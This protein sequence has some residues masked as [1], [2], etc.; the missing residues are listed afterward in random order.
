M[1]GGCGGKTNHDRGE[2]HNVLSV[3]II[4][5]VPTHGC[6]FPCLNCFTADQR[7]FVNHPLPFH[8]PNTIFI[9]FYTH[10]FKVNPHESRN[11]LDTY[12]NNAKLISRVWRQLPLSALQIIY[13][14]PWLYRRVQKLSNRA[15]SNFKDLLP[16][17]RKAPL[18]LGTNLEYWLPHHASFRFNQSCR[19]V[20]HPAAACRRRSGML[21]RAG[22][23]SPRFG[24]SYEIVGAIRKGSQPLG[25][26]WGWANSERGGWSVPVGGGE[27]F[28]SGGKIYSGL[29]GRWGGWF[30]QGCGRVC[31][32]NFAVDTPDWVLAY[33]SESLVVSTCGKTWWDSIIFVKQGTRCYLISIMKDGMLGT[34]TVA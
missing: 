27:V 13:A 9:Q 32:D 31:H 33:D 34:W 20:I 3:V 26:R 4:C 23:Y 21:A 19:D 8:S 5:D 24:P 15:S 1:F 10:K 22:R 14:I 30:I 16:T 2:I 7:I 6:N 17:Q 12:N 25:E 18:N 28:A 11:S 29:E